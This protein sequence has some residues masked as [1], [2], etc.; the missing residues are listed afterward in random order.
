ME[1]IMHALTG[2]EDDT[3]SGCLFYT[4]IPILLIFASFSYFLFPHVVSTGW[5][6]GLNVTTDILLFLALPCFIVPFS[7]RR[8]KLLLILIVLGCILLQLS[9]FPLF[10]ESDDT[11]VV[12][13]ASSILLYIGCAVFLLG[14]YLFTVTMNGRR[15]SRIR[16][17]ITFSL[18]VSEA[19]VTFGKEFLILSRI[20]CKETTLVKSVLIMFSYQVYSNYSLNGYPGYNKNT[21]PVYNKKDLLLKPITPYVE[22]IAWTIPSS[23]VPEDGTRKDWSLIMRIA[24]PKGFVIET[25]YPLKVKWDWSESV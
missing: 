17:N 16:E 22:E 24:L 10:S 15:S 1:G 20:A 18:S 23:L 13:S 4:G 8:T 7:D 21:L 6:S 14:L 25:T 5:Y 2:E 12:P 9:T 19:R 3:Q 11:V